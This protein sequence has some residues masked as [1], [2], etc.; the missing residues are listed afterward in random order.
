MKI[1]CIGDSNTWGFNL[2]SGS[3][4][5]RRWISLLQ[6]SLTEDLIIDEGLNG[7]TFCFDDPYS[8]GRNGLH[9]LPDILEGHP[10]TDLFVIML[11]TNDLKN[12]FHA[13]P[14]EIA[15]GALAFITMIKETCM[16]H[17]QI[18]LISPIDLDD[19]APDLIFGDEFDTE[20]VQKS[21]Q[22][23]PLF[24]ALAKEEDIHFLDAALIAHASSVDG[25]HFDEESHSQFSIALKDFI[26][27]LKL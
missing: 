16:N 25:V 11:G 22:L 26:T 1:V 20:S 7:R 24:Q 23:S 18:L 6:E 5:R 17:P 27:S 19:A 12:F 8:P 14:E 10:D 13:S 15:E 3:Q 4:Y 2:A 9:D 21:H